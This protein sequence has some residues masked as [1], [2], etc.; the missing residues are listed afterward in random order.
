MGQIE[1]AEILLRAT[2]ELLTI[3]DDNSNELAH[4]VFYDGAT[5]DG[6]CLLD[7]IKVWLDDQDLNRE[8]I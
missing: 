2:L 5:C 1:R 6:A 4:T 8:Q 3:I 7:D